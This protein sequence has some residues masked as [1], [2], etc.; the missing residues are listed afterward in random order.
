M[1]ATFVVVSNVVGLW[2][3]VEINV[4]GLPVVAVISV[5]V[6]DGFCVVRTVLLVIL[7]GLF[8][9]E[10]SIEEFCTV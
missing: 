5:T 1:D 8:V 10:S 3:I 6:L 2:E 7:G 4:E 9:V